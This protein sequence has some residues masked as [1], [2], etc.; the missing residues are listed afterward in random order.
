[1]KKS[2][3]IKYRRLIVSSEATS[4][5]IAE[6]IG[7]GCTAA[8]VRAAKRRLLHY[9]DFKKANREWR[10]KNSVSANARDRKRRTQTAIFAINHND[11]WMPHEDEMVL[12]TTI[13][14]VLTAKMLGRTIDAVY[15]RR[16]RILRNEQ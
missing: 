5:K 16:S 3:Y 1:V 10:K 2:K 13:K 4:Q 12:D 8:A 9:N 15:Q 7:D 11:I 6:F 14:S